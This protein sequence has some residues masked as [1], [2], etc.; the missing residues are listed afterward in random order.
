MK[1]RHHRRI[2]AKRNWKVG[3]VIKT[4]GFRDRNGAFYWMVEPE[5]FCPDDGIPRGAEVRGPFNTN[6]EMSAHRQIT[7]LGLDCV[8]T[9]GGTWDLAWDRLQ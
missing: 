8:V 6:A 5:G 4:R 2:S 1:N 9:E 3:D 7:L